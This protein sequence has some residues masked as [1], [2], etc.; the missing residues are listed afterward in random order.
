MEI[1]PFPQDPNLCPRSDLLSYIKRTESFRQIGNRFSEQLFISYCKPHKAVTSCT[2]ARWQKTILKRAGI[3]TSIFTAHSFRSAVVST[4]NL[5]G[6][7]LADIMKLADW[8]SQT[9]F[10][11]FYKK[12][13]VPSVAPVGALV[14][15]Q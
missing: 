8:S 7:S 5:K 6:A 12:S 15:A 1:L 10:N 13:L 14:L 4:A 3:D 2:I 9:M 11:K